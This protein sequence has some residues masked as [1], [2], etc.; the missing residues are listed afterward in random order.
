M[1]R[2]GESKIGY[3]GIGADGRP[4]DW[5]YGWNPGGMG[6]SAGCDGCWARALAKRFSAC[7]DC[8]AFKVHFHEERLD[9]PAYTKKPGVVLANFT[10]D[11]LDIQRAHLDSF[12]IYNHMMAEPRHVYVTLTKNPDHLYAVQDIGDAHIFHGLTLRTQAEADVKMGIFSQIPGNLWLSLEP[13]QERVSFRWAKWAPVIDSW[14]LDSLKPIKGVIVGHDNR[15]GKPGT[16]TLEHVRS[17]VQQCRAAGV[18]VFVKQIHHKGRVLRASKPEEFALFPQDIQ[19]RDL[20]WS[21][22]T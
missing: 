13:L 15:P 4:V 10:N 7:P 16:D 2:M 6:C 12:M 17:V 14:H 9:Q 21:L 11:W 8:Q 20:P 19:L 3:R 22:P 1:K 5:Y 18:N